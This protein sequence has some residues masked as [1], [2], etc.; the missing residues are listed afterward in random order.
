M[1]QMYV[2]FIKYGLVFKWF[3]TIFDRAVI[4]QILRCAS[5]RI[6]W[7]RGDLFSLCA[8]FPCTSLSIF[9]N[10]QRIALRSDMG[11]LK[12]QKESSN[13]DSNGTMT[14]SNFD[15]SQPFVFN[16]TVLHVFV[17]FKKTSSICSVQ[18]L[19][20]EKPFRFPTHRMEWTDL[21]KGFLLNSR[22]CQSSQS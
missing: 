22:N 2:G 7:W 15:S 5:I 4:R 21:L 17:L 16:T 19:P 18:A 13:W 8:F 10:G 12:N 20:N 14:N 6:A 1:A 9:L 3:S 11:I